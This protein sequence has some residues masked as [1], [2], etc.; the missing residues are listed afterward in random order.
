M[1]TTTLTFRIFKGSQLVGEQSLAQSVIKLGKVSSAHVRLDDDSVSRMHAIIEVN[2]GVVSIIDLGST[3]GTIV[4]GAKIN[5]ATLRSGDVITLGET[6]V[7]LALA[8]TA[9]VVVASV[10]SV[11]SVPAPVPVPALVS[12]PVAPRAPAPVVAES[13]SGA[14]EVA[15]MF[16]ESVISVKHVSNAKAG[17]LSRTTLGLFATGA[18]ALLSTAIAFGGSV[19]TAG[20]DKAALDYWTHI[21]NKPAR[22][23]RAHQGSTGADLAGLGGLG[24]GIATLGLGLARARKEKQQQP[25]YRIG[26]AAGVELP[27]ETAPSADYALVAPKG[28]DFVFNYD[29]SMEGEM[30]VD[31]TATSLATLAQS[32]RPSASVAGAIELPIP[33]RARIRAK[34]GQTTFL[35]SSVAKPRAEANPLFAPDRRMLGYAAASLGVHLAAILFLQ[36]IPVDDSSAN[37]D[38]DNTELVGMRTSDTSKEDLV[39]EVKPTDGGDHASETRGDHWLFASGIWLSG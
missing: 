34:S 10:A 37:L 15:A 39:E 18:A 4:N 12:A 31:G 23:F 33:A 36:T 14:V 29:A 11:A 5:K 3:R 35:V 2:N 6:R 21:Q 38:L 1:T 24:L 30:T 27:L 32:A 16:G 17:K 20:Q 19:R 28:D 13:G 25:T 26:T 7:E 9:A 8:T 22:A